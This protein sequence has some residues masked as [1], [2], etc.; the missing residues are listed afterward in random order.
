LTSLLNLPAPGRCHTLYVV[1]TT[2]QSDVF[3]LNSRLARFTAIPMRSE[4][5][6]LSHVETPFIPKLQ[7][8]FAEFL[9]HGSLEHLRTFIPIYLCRFA[10]RT[11]YSLL[12]EVF[13]GSMLTTSL[14]A[15]ALPFGSRG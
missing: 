7:G 13:L 5:Q 6:A 14:W 15:C 10:V 8:Q 12:C 3:L 4:G 11:V 9:D 2:S 1:F